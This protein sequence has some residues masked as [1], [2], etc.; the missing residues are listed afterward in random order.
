MPA[1]KNERNTGSP[2]PGKDS[3]SPNVKIK[4]GA[5]GLLFGDL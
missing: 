5:S 1:S 3:N 4:Q 2:E